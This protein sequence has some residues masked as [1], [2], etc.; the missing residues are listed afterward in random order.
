MPAL[1]AD[2]H[3]HTPASADYR[4]PGTSAREIVE[5]ALAAGLDVYAATDHF[6]V[7]FAAELIAAAEQV[8]AETGRR[9]MVVPGTELR[10][11]YRGDEAHITALLPPDGF[12]PLFAA[13]LDILGLTLPLAASEDLPFFTH[14]HDPVDVARIIHALGGIACVAHAD[15][16]FGD[17]R[18]FDSG[19]FSRLA[20]EPAVAAV[21]FLDP[22]TGEAAKSLHVGLRTISCS[23]S[24]C[25][26]H[27]G[28][29][30]AHLE[31][32]DLSFASLKVA[33]RSGAVSC[34][35]AA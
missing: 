30:R 12:E 2:L 19:L 16:W 3:N 1:A 4:R 18:L 5:T 25:C 34:E 24:H 29:R 35:V 8:A 28:S 32:D 33:L 22:D 26:E 21:D 17:Y 14:E 9:L 13:L 15:R 27:V 11:T 23:D 7:G 31:M 20:D 10:I 6:S